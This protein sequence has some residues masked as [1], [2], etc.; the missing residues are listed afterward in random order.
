MCVF[1]CVCM[2]VCVS[3]C[4]CVCV[5]VCVRCVCVC[6]QSFVHAYVFARVVAYAN[7][8]GCVKCVVFGFEAGVKMCCYY[9]SMDVCNQIITQ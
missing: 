1:V 7:D 9:S 8:C 6:L 2:C 4:V 5:C 3:V